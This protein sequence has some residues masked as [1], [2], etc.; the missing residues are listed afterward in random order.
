ME[1]PIFNSKALE[2]VISPDDLEKAV[3]V[4]T[5]RVWLILC[6]CAALLAGLLAW[7]IWGTVSTGVTDTGVVVAGGEVFCLL[8]ESEVKQVHV[9][10]TAEVNGVLATVESLS[11]LPVSREEAG[12]LLK[13]QYLVEQIMTDEWEFPVTLKV[14]DKDSFKPRMT[15]P[16]QI[17]T[18][19]VSPISLL[20]DG[21]N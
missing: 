21:L 18:E 1:K 7:G 12:D 17:M 3:H 13:S 5:P 2:A 6:A 14:K 20:L 16:V 11:D 19:R 15:C 4:T 8:N 10:E 9:G